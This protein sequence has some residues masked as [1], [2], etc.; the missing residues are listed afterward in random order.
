MADSA[1][2]KYVKNP[3]LEIQKIISRICRLDVR[4][5]HLDYDIDELNDQ[6]ILSFD[7]STGKFIP[8]QPSGAGFEKGWNAEVADYESLPDPTIN[9]GQVYLVVNGLWL[10]LPPKLAG[11]WRS[12]GVKW[13]RL[14]KIRDFFNTTNFELFDDADPSKRA[15]FSISGFTPGS[16][17][18]FTLP[19]KVCVLAALSDIPETHTHIQAEASTMW[20]IT[21]NLDYK[22]IVIVT[23]ILG[24]KVI[25]EAKHIDM[26]N[27]QITFKKAFIGKAFFR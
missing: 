16:K 3:I 15:A 18:M 24:R 13:Y 2:D 22:P 17:R 14:G 6:D 5:S 4:D 1:F 7:S 8:L 12:D 25:A 20:N 10:T 19:D 21:H 11:L 23:D 27:V 26:D 9:S